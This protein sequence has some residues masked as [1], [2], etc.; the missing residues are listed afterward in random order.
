MH[1]IWKNVKL[2]NDLKEQKCDHIITCCQQKYKHFTNNYK[3][4]KTSILIET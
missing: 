1:A 4:E 2:N 3:L